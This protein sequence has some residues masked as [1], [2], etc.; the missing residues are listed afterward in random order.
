MHNVCTLICGEHCIFV[1]TIHSGS[2]HFKIMLCMCIS[3][4]LTV[5]ILL[6]F[7]ADLVTDVNCCTGQSIVFVN[8][9]SLFVY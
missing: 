8:V 9:Q 6:I 3:I 7:S 5:I 2:T 4:K 1:D